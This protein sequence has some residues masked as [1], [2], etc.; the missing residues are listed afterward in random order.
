VAE[1]LDLAVLFRIYSKRTAVAGAETNT[2]EPAKPVL[3]GPYSAKP[4]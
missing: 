1:T 4:Q 3:P 2:A